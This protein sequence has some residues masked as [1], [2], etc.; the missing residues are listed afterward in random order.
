MVDGSFFG[1]IMVIGLFGMCLVYCLNSLLRLKVRSDKLLLVGFVF[2]LA[3]G[4]YI[5][6]FTN[7]TIFTFT[8][9]VIIIIFVSGVIIGNGMRLKKEER[10]MRD[11]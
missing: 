8:F 1:W 6:I 4:L 10:E 9:W 7:L 2:Y 3:S 5:Q 11:R